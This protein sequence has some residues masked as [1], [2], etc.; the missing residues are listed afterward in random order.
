MLKKFQLEDCKPV[1]T[2]MTVWCK[3]RKEDE[4]KVVDP[5]HYKSM[6]GSLL[7]VTTSK[8]NVKQAIGMVA[9]FQA[10]PKENHVQVVKISFSYLKGAIYFELW[11]PSKNSFSL[12]AYQNAYWAG[13][14]DEK[15]S[16][17]GGEFFLGESLV[18]WTS[19]KQSLI[20]LSTTEAEYIAATKCCTQVEWI[21]Q[22]LQDIKVVFE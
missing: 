15:E 4:S 5:K 19:K 22:T 11:Y 3:L 2:P 14:V 12:K 9:R 10:A 21:K 18:A 17:S 1:C 7:Y 20:S 6:I 16:T 8:P 13:Y